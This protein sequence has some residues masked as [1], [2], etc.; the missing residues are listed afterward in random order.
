[1]SRSLAVVL[2]AA[3]VP[4]S[5]ADVYVLRDGDRITGKTVFKAAKT[6]T[7]Q[8]PYGRLT[9]PRDKIERVLHDDGKQE[10]LNPPP[11]P[12]PAPPPPVHLIL[13]ITG[14]TFWYAWD[15]KATVDATLRLAASLDEE[16]VATWID[17]RLDPKE[18]PD[19]T[20]NAF[21]F[22]PED[23]TTLAAAGV[24]IPPPE[25]RPGRIVLR[26]E[27]PA[28]RVGRRRLRLAYQVNE[29]TAAEPA[30]R[31]LAQASL[32]VELRADAPTFLQLQQDGGQMGFSR[33][34]MKNV[35]TFRMTAKTE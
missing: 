31:D 22:L 14:R 23:V 11:E 16:P 15:P 19:A 30:W 18:I 2:L 13:V 28:E 3:A 6:F 34:R 12:P 24:S 25:A 4:V 29:A 21:S 33:H 35:D 5:A 10:V 9:I 8:T 1:V 26:V 20:V 27:V 17:A 7:V 32:D